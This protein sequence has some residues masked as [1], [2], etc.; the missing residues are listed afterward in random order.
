V[1]QVVHA[2]AAA[3]FTASCPSVHGY[4]FLTTAAA[5]LLDAF[6]SDD[7]RRRFMH[8]MVEGRVFGTMCLSEPQAGSSLADIRTRAEPVEGRTYRI[9]GDKMWISGA[10]H[11]LAENIVHLVLAKI[12]GGPPGV[13][14]ISLFAVPKFRIL[15]DGTRGERNAVRVSGI[16]HKMG[17][18][19]IVNCA[20][21]F[22][23]D[24]ECLG[25]LVGEPHKG[26]ACMFHMMNEARIGVGLG[27]S[28]VAYAGFAY[29]LAYAKERRQGRSPL[30]KDPRAPGA[31]H[32]ARRREA[33]A[34]GAE[35]VRRRRPRA[36]PLLRSPRGRRAGGRLGG[37][38]ARGRAPARGADADR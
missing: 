25:E 18:R 16:N 13:K 20:L 9:T 29:S 24:G 31:H 38:Q 22:G 32:R 34:A 11:D 14:G 27:A 26:L 17:Q 36:V 35:G 6:A 8:P 33:H 19:G 37:S 30:Q 23:Q 21:V 3:V 2:A 5:N 7:Q 4:P 12:P 1:P 15:A 10:D 28:A